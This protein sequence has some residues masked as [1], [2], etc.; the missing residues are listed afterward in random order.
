MRS[1][2]LQLVEAVEDSNGCDAWRS[3]NKAL[4]HGQHAR[5]TVP[6]NL[7]FLSLKKYLM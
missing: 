4:V 2:A 1:R 3:L 5:F 7:S 6:Y